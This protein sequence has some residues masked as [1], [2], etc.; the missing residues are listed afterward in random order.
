[1]PR[2]ERGLVTFTVVV[3]PAASGPSLAHT[4]MIVDERAGVHLSEQHLDT[5]DRNPGRHAAAAFRVTGASWGHCTA[6]CNVCISV[7]TASAAV[8]RVAVKF[9]AIVR[10]L[11]ERSVAT[12]CPILLIAGRSAF[13]VR[14]L[15]A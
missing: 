6:R 12:N 5:A 2:Q 3:N 15:L 4:L 10:A 11:R 1:D 14:R 9:D 13:R 7:R 8:R